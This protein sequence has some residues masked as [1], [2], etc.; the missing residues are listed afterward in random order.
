MDISIK[1]VF[2]FSLNYKVFEKLVTCGKYDGIHSCLTVVTNADKVRRRIPVCGSVK[3]I[4][5]KTGYLWMLWMGLS[6][7][8]LPKFAI[9]IETWFDWMLLLIVG[10]FSSTHR[11]WSTLLT[12]GMDC[13]TRNFQYR[14]SR[15]TSR[16]WIWT[17]PFGPSLPESWR[18]T[19]IETFWWLGVH[20]TF[21]VCFD[22]PMGEQFQLQWDYFYSLPCGWKL[23]SISTWFPRRCS[24]ATDWYVW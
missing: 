21:L 17:F 23:Q 9:L 2:S 16:C 18:E 19:M 6:V 20:L 7:A 1:P 5:K 3:C 12:S 15:M 8:R 4:E 13:K 22:W 11:Y 24:I 10:F 14:K